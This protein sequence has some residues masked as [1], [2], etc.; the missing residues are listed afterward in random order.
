LDTVLTLQGD[1]DAVEKAIHT[2][3]LTLSQPSTRSKPTKILKGLE[4]MHDQLSEKVEEL[5][6]SL[7]IPDSYPDLHGV[8]LDF[9][10]TLLMARDLKIN[11]RK[12]A[13]GSFF[14]WDR[15]DQAV[16]GRSNPLGMFYFAHFSSFSNL[17]TGTKLHQVTRKAIVKWQPALM[18]SI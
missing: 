4:E 10:R 7:N 11:I 5:Y 18:K 16:G 2:A 6:V 12:R 9:V 3:K 17:S 15:L 1:L 14:E 13:I 8:G